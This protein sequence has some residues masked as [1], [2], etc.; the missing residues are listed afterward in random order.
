MEA[1]QLRKGQKMSLES[2]L[3]IS[4]ALKG[5]PGFP[6]KNKGKKLSLETRLKMSIAQK[7]RLAWN[8]GKK[9]TWTISEEGRKVISE[10][11]KKR[12]RGKASPETKKRISEARK[13]KIVPLERKQRIRKTLMGHL[14]SEETR[15][16]MSDKKRQAHKD[17]KYK[18]V[19]N[20]MKNRY[21]H[22]NYYSKKNNK[23]FYY[24]S[25]WELLAYQ[26]FEQMNKVIAYE[27]EP[28][29][30]SYFDD[31]D[32]KEHSYTPDILVTYDD[33]SKEL[34]EIKP[35]KNL[36]DRKNILKFEAGRK[37]AQE[38]NAKFLVLTKENLNELK[39]AI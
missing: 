12:V 32:G 28:I 17:G 34:I 33:L 3:R 21:I 31:N 19:Q 1:F 18:N 37:F 24:R 22:G 2:R 14:V 36:T 39:M 35:T 26:I 5:H 9:N 29:I 23:T 30:I 25:S 16:K 4:Q 11:Q 8:K 10:T 13:G 20:G 27:A 38:N 15:K 7:G 6:S